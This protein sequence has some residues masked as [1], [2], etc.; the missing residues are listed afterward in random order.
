MIEKVR[1]QWMSVFILIL[2]VLAIIVLSCTS[3]FEDKMDITFIVIMLTGLCTV[4]IIQNHR[5]SEKLVRLA[6]VDS[7][8]GGNNL[9]KFRLLVEKELARDWKNLYMVRIDIDNF[10]LINDMYGYE[11]GDRILLAMNHL[12]SKLLS[13]K[14]IYGRVVNDNFLCLIVSDNDAAIL[15][16]GRLFRLQFKE[17]MAEWERHY[18]VNFTTGVYKITEADKDVDKIIDR[19]TMA[20]R[21]AKTLPSDRKFAFYSDDM[22]NAALQVKDIEDA[23]YEALADKEF[24]PY[25]QP[26]YDLKTGQIEG[27]EALVRWFH[28]ERML[29]PAYFVPVLEKNGFIA[30]VDLYMFERVCSMQ[31]CWLDMGLNPVPVS[32]NQSKP[33]V[34]TPDYTEQLIKIVQRYNVPPHLLELEL[35][36]GLIHENIEELKKIVDKLHEAGFLVCIDDFG[37]GYSSLNLLK[38]I[39]ADVLKIDKAFLD[40]AEENERAEIILQNIVIMA[41]KLNMSV[42][43][44]GVET[45]KQSR[46]MEKIGCS[47]AQGHLFAK[48]MPEADYEQALRK[49]AKE[50]SDKNQN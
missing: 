49:R 33:L 21:N 18:T 17:S 14:G 29:P 13:R 37:S 43:V 46:L 19:A 5:S 2:A 26:K 24:L 32:V 31:R 9:N 12:I 23:M 15:E 48:A 50:K 40:N 6:Y 34:Y 47:V 44:E 7:L 16:L 1:K 42:V 28:D 3:V 35:L 36:E 4:V 41:E 11:E 30:K 20:H 10:K 22:R 45:K 39:E 8:T 38:D 25:Y 27:A